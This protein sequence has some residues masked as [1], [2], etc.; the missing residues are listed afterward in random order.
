MRS[1]APPH[2]RARACAGRLL[3]AASMVLA[4]ASHAS[5]ASADVQACLGASEKG[6][7]ARGAGKLREAREQFLLCSSDGCP[8]MVR[9]DCAQWQGEVIA[10]LP[11]IV[12]GAK[13]RAG[14]DLFDVTVSIDGEPLVKKLDGKSLPVD[15]G[16]HTFKFEMAG[17]PPVIERALIK[18][19]EKTRVIAATF[20]VGAAASDAPP[21][22]APVAEDKSAAGHERG[23]TVFPWIVVGLG[24]ATMGAG[25]VVLL[26][27]PSLPPGCSQATKTCT[28]LPGEPPSA[29]AKRQEDAGRSESQPTEGLIIGAIGLGVVGAGLLW[30]FLEP[31]GPARTG[32]LHF[33]PWA[34]PGTAGGALGASF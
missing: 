19:G 5:R 24:V 10:T 30:H 27:S 28:R 34:A 16:P 13:D 25:L 33:T 12:L 2:V 23:H 1:L 18:E 26:T 11:S 14:R 6:Q 4:F 9:R 3:V 29:F 22:P 21:T 8:A 31:T 20:A 17:A 7:R 15:P 32:A